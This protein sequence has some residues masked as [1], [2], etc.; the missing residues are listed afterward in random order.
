MQTFADNI[1]KLIYTERKFCI[2]S[3]VRLKFLPHDP[4]DSNS[5][6]E[7]IEAEWRIYASVI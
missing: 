6:G 1:F 5:A 3:Q 7:L 4:F 2:M